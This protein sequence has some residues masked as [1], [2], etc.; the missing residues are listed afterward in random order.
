L[1]KS[2]AANDSYSADMSKH[3]LLALAASLAA[4]AVANPQSPSSGANLDWLVGHWCGE[5][6]GDFIEEQWMATRGD[7]MLGLSRTIRGDRTKNFEYM[8]VVVENGAVTF[9]A[10]PQGVPPVAFKRTAGGKDWARFEN[11]THDFPNRVEYRRT[12]TGLHAEIAGPGREG[13]E[14]VIPFEYGA[15]AR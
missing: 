3:K 12:A 7:V 4:A 14:K 5:Q 11:K 2:G 6:D 13:N 15:C 1:Y 10:Q 9:I 8:R